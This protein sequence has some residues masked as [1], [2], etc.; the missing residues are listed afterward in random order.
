MTECGA[1]LK[2]REEG[3]EKCLY[4]YKDK[5]RQEH[6]ENMSHFNIMASTLGSGFS[7]ICSALPCLI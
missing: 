1:S 5:N 2:K 6:A 3:V 4:L 7:H